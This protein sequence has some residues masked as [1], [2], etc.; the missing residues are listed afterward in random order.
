MVVVEAQNLLK[1]SGKLKSSPEK[2]NRDKY[3]RYYRDHGHDTEDYFRL[4]IAIE[5]LIEASHLAKFVRNN[6]P[7]RTDAPLVEL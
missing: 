2:R 7:V 6:K 5:K 3:C 4:K 1:M